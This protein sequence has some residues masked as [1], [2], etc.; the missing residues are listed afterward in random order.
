M[1][2]AIITTLPKPHG[3]SPDP[4]TDILRAG[5]RELIQQAVEAELSVLLETHS[6]D[7]TEDGRARLVR[8]SHLPEGDVITG[9]G[10]VPVKVPRVRD[11]ADSAEKIRFTSTI[12]SPYPRKAKSIQ[13]LLSWLFL[14]GIPTGDFHEALPHFWAQ[15][16]VAVLDHDIAAQS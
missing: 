10:A 9:I 14:K 1:T 6:G 11:R 12:L 16:S 7:R 2:K 4:L 5:A 13:E 8:H 15:C 3:F